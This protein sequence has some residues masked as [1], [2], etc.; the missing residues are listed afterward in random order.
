MQVDSDPELGRS[1]KGPYSQLDTP[2]LWTGN[3]GQ[4]CVTCR[5][6]RPLRAKHCAVTDRCIENFDHFCPWVGNSIGKVGH[7]ILSQCNPRLS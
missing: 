1:G 4:L 3:W 2:A 6:V 7:P 5:I